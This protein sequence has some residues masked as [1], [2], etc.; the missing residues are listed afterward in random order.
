VRRASG[1]LFE[2]ALLAACCQCAARESRGQ[3]Q[4]RE[5]GVRNNDDGAAAQRAR[6]QGR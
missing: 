2:T 6:Q 1:A 4:L 3:K 5:G